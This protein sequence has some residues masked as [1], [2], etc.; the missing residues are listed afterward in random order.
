MDIFSYESIAIIIPKLVADFPPVFLRIV[1][2][3]VFF[4][5]NGKA[6][7]NISFWNQED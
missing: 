6:Q 1:D 7:L 2:Y 4:T 5:L 3:F